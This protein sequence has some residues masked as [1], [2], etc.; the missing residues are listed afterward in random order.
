MVNGQPTNLD[1]RCGC[2][3]PIGQTS[4]VTKEEIAEA[5]Y[6]AAEASTIKSAPCHNKPDLNFAP[7]AQIQSPAPCPNHERIRPR[8]PGQMGGP[9]EGPLN[10]GPQQEQSMAFTFDT[11]CRCAPAN[12]P[13]GGP[14]NYGR[15]WT[16][17]SNMGPNIDP[18]LIGQD[19]VIPPDVMTAIRPQPPAARVS[20][21]PEA[22][23][24]KFD[25]PS[26]FMRKVMCPVV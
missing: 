13:T 18:K 8:A 20:C 16:R 23:V 14:E 9:F 4:N 25:Q 19:P 10:L 3:G 7:K 1:H 15:E 22:D 21:A 5:V 24:S 12:P 17:I 11:Q 6:R 26:T 2:S